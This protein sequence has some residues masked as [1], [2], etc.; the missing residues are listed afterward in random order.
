MRVY[1]PTIVLRESPR[2]RRGD[3]LALLKRGDQQS[4]ADRAHCSPT[5]VSA[6]LN[7]RT[8]QDTALAKNIIRVAEHIAEINR[9]RR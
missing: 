9:F 8:S 7:G 3:L 5:T 1:E 2:Y 4:I 6:V